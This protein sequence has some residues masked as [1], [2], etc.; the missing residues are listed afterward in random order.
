MDAD[1]TRAKLAE[2]IAAAKG[3]AIGRAVQWGVD[4]CS[5]WVASIIAEA[6]GYD[7]IAPWR[8]T[9]SSREGAEDQLAR[10]DIISGLRRAAKS[11]HWRRITAKEAQPGDIGAALTEC[12]PVTAIFDGNIWLS[13]IDFGVAYHP[14][15]KIR[16]AWS[17]L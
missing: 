17:V 11:H 2:A 6:L 4:D 1:V 7:P 16:F 14:H 8:G 15:S 12:G 5:P 13:R 3:T 9:Y 10:T